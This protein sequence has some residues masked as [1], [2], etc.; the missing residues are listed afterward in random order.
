MTGHVPH[1][2]SWERYKYQPPPNILPADNSISYNPTHKAPKYGRMGEIP[3]FHEYKF[4]LSQ[5]GDA[6]EDGAAVVP[7]K[8]PYINHE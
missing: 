8:L 6:E 7:E 2:W 4:A 1:L 3:E 5:T